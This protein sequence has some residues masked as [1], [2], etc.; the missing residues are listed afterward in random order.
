MD[1]FLVLKQPTMFLLNRCFLRVNRCTWRP[2]PVHPGWPVGLVTWP[3]NL[4]K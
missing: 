3:L 4:A 2:R 1:G